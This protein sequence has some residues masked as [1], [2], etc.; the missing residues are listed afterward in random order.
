[1][2]VIDSP[3]WNFELAVCTK[4]HISQTPCPQCMAE[5]DPDIKVR[6]NDWDRTILCSNSNLTIQDLLPEK[7]RDWLLERV[8][9]QFSVLS[10]T[11][12]CYFL[13]NCFT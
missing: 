13:N 7:D 3:H 5:H 1:M 8:V 11:L 6:I 9:P 12:N 4:H 10:I 2:P